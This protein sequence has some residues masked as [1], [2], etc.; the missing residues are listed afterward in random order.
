MIEFDKTLLS[1]SY[2]SY[3]FGDSCNWT[4]ALNATADFQSPVKVALVAE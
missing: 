4:F 2:K 3:L 1:F